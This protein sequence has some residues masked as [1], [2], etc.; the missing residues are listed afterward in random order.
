MK[1][2]ILFLILLAGTINAQSWCPPGAQWHFRLYYP[3]MPYYNGYLKVNNTGTVSVNGKVCN[4][5]IGDYYGILNYSS[6]PSQTVSNFVSLQTYEANKVTYVYNPNTTSFDTLANFNAGIGDKWHLI[7]FPPS[8]Y[9]TTCNFAPPLVTV[10]D[11]SHVTIN[12]FYLKRLAITYQLNSQNHQDTIIER[13]SCITSF[14]FPFYHC[15]ID[16]PYYGTFVC[17][18]DNTF[19]LYKRAG[20]TNACDYIAGFSENQLSVEQIRI[21]PN[22]T[23]SA[24]RI[25]MGKSRSQFFINLFN[26]Q[27]QLIR[28]QHEIGADAILNIEDVTPGLYILHIQSNEESLMFKIIKD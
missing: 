27:G 21:F 19:P 16:G 15:V 25:S 3:Y 7:K 6:S 20:I 2:L 26:P 13:I 5:L 9:S 18:S 24:L 22:P 8:A 1:K 14:L 10:T 17:Y 23:T 4:N 12:G 11:T 28:T